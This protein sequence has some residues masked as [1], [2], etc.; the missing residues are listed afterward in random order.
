M[1]TLVATR[2]TRTSEII[3]PEIEEIIM[4]LSDPKY[5]TYVTH[6]GHPSIVVFPGIVQHNQMASML[7]LRH[8]EDGEH[9]FTEGCILGAG[10]VS[11]P[12]DNLG[13]SSIVCY[14]KS[15]SLGVGVREGEE[16]CMWALDDTKI[17]RKQL[18]L[19]EFE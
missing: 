19:G 7:N 13:N 9:E 3:S 18:R 12:T 16:G 8:R 15:V 1:M 17:A 6:N 4:P 2:S 10:F 11:F 5:I 14:G